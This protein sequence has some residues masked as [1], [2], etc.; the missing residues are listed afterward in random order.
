VRI[1]KLHFWT[2][3]LCGVIFK[4][5]LELQVVM[6]C[7]LIERA[8]EAFVAKMDSGSPQGWLSLAL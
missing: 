7:I 4:V 8:V 1:M 2:Y 5:E 6:N 3:R